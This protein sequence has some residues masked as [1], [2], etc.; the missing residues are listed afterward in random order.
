VILHSVFL[1]KNRIFPE[2]LKLRHESSFKSWALRFGL[3][4]AGRS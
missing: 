2:S 4:S 1:R 3:E